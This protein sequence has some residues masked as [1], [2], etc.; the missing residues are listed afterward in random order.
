VN[1]VAVA[2]AAAAADNTDDDDDDDDVSEVEYIDAGQNCIRTAVDRSSIPD[3]A[4]EP[5]EVEEAAAG[6]VVAWAVKTELAVPVPAVAAAVAVQVCA[7]RASP[8]FAVE[9][10][11][12]AAAWVVLFSSA[13]MTSPTGAS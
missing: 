3:S 10:V 13:V 9:S 8:Q 4:R 1:I 7:E 5:V 12:V 2:V 11:V 6:E